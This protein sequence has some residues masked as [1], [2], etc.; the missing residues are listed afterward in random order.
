MTLGGVSAPEPGAQQNCYLFPEPRMLI[1]VHSGHK[2]RL[3]VES[4]QW[5]VPVLK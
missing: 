2:S 1:P 5:I 3:T 4:P